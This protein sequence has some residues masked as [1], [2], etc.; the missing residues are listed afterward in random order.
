MGID[1]DELSALYLEGCAICG[2]MEKLCIDHD[3]ACCDTLPA[4]GKCV[5][6]PLCGGCNIRVGHWEANP[7]KARKVLD[8]VTTSRRRNLKVRPAMANRAA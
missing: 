3:H 8:Y 5:R 7:A 1:P 4:C 2:K 6:G